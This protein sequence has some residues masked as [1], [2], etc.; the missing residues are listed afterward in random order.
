M[1]RL[2]KDKAI[3]LR[4][5]KLGE[6]D[7]IVVLLG[8]SSGQIRA[9]AKGVRKPTSRLGGRIA[10]FN[11]IQGQFHRGQNLDTI[12]QSELV[13]GYGDSISADY[14]SFAAAKVIAEMTQK[15]SD[16]DPDSGA[17][18]FDLLHGALAALS[19]RRHAPNL[20]A[21]SYLLR[22][23]AI[24][25]W[26]IQLNACAVCDSKSADIYFS[27]A[28][29][30]VVCEE[31]LGASPVPITKEMAANLIALLTGQ[32]HLLDDN[33]AGGGHGTAALRFAGYWSQWHL[34][35]KLK[36]LPFALSGNSMNRED[37]L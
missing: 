12:S 23:S 27:P 14:Q 33:E 3:V 36:S 31:C 17:E 2:Y 21:A 20:I 1:H 26:A 7:R 18:L 9:V 15:L 16:K 10:P 28:Q 22:A 37:T 13:S 19:T 34:E 35:Q 4:Q 8:Q 30:G 29:G 5:Y 24:A 25:G 11:L 6:A 32:W